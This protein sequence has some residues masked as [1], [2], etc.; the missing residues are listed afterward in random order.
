M[1][2]NLK[3]DQVIINGTI[4]ELVYFKPPIEITTDNDTTKQYIYYEQQ[5]FAP[6]H[7]D[8]LYLKWSWN[9]YKLDKNFKVI[10]VT[11]Q[12]EK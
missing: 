1:K 10:T 11:H 9:F 6:A 8:S 5:H 12:A 3:T 4:G 7:K 2:E